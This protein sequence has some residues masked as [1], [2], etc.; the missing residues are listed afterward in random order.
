MTKSEKIISLIASA[1]IVLGI[2]VIVATTFLKPSNDGLIAESVVESSFDETSESIVEDT[3]V[4]IVKNDLADFGITHSK[5]L[6]LSQTTGPFKVDV[7]AVNVASSDYNTE[8]SSF[9]E[10][11][12]SLVAVY[13]RVENTS[14]DTFSIHPD[15]GTLVTNTQEQSNAKVFISDAVGGDFFGQV[16][17][18]GSV[19][20]TLDSEAT[21]LESLRFIVASPYADDFSSVGEDLEFKIELK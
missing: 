14:T 13:V 12:N 4:E 17:K 6:N 5:E 21:D 9:M 8:Y 20:F 7:L 16:V 3:S 1:A 19:Y 10:D 2:V 11:K 18:E 15:Q